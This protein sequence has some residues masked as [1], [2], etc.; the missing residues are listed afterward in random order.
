MQQQQIGLSSSNAKPVENQESDQ[1]SSS[2]NEQEANNKLQTQMTQQQNI[3]ANVKPLSNQQQYENEEVVNQSSA[4]L[5]EQVSTNPGQDAHQQTQQ[6]FTVDSVQQKNIHQ[7]Q[8]KNSSENYSFIH[9]PIVVNSNHRP[10]NQILEKNKENI[11]AELQPMPAFPAI[12]ND[13]TN[14]HQNETNESLLNLM[15]SL[16]NHQTS[17]ILPEINVHQFNHHVPQEQQI[18]SPQSNQLSSAS[19]LQAATASQQH[20]NQANISFSQY[21][22][23]HQG[24]LANNA[25]HEITEGKDGSQLV[26]SQ[27]TYL[28]NHNRPLSGQPQQINQ[29]FEHNVGQI[30]S[31]QEDPLKVDQIISQNIPLS[32]KPQQVQDQGHINVQS[33]FF[34]QQPTE[35]QHQQSLQVPQ[36]INA[37]NEQVVQPNQ[38]LQQ[39]TFE[40]N[41][42][43]QLIGQLQQINAIIN[44]QST[45]SQENSHILA[46]NTIPP[47]PIS[48]GHISSNNVYSSQQQQ[49]YNP[50][51]VFVQTL[52]INK[53]RPENLDLSSSLEPSIQQQSTYFQNRPVLQQNVQG[54]HV[55]HSVQLNQ[56]PQHLVN[57]QDKPFSEHSQVNNIQN[58]Y[59]TQQQGSISSQ[60]VPSAQQLSNSEDN[61]HKKPNATILNPLNEP[62]AFSP[63]QQPHI[64]NQGLIHHQQQ[65][66][67]LITLG[68]NENSGS[69]TH[70][71]T[72]SLENKPLHQGQI[73]HQQMN[74]TNEEKPIIDPLQ[75][76]QQHQQSVQHQ[77]T[78]QQN[79]QEQQS[80]Q[81]Q[82]LHQQSVQHQQ[83]IQQQ[84]NSNVKPLP[85]TYQS[86]QQQFLQQHQ[87]IL[88]QHQGSNENILPESYQG[89]QYQHQQQHFI[90][91]Q[92]ALN[93]DKPL[94]D[95]HQ[96]QHFILHQN[97]LPGS[98]QV[99]QQQQYIPQP[100]HQHQFSAYEV[101]LP[102]SYP[103]QQPQYPQLPQPIDNQQ[104]SFQQPQYIHQQQN[105]QQISQP[106]L[107]FQQ[108]QNIQQQASISLE[109][110]IQQQQ[111][112][113]QNLHQPQFISNEQPLIS[114]SNIQIQQQSFSAQ[115]TPQYQLHQTQHQ[116]QILPQQQFISNEK[117][118]I[119]TEQKLLSTTK[120]ASTL[121]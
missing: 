95:S 112:Q 70:L 104:Q 6:Q 10:I 73:I 31:S 24:Q 64:A 86:Y 25:Q 30:S 84:F 67:Q 18:H 109:H 16:E 72:I 23:T 21:L 120:Y 65:T 105:I 12:V 81:Q 49:G 2:L 80:L 63:F 57:S 35:N 113:S 33:V 97:P 7:Q 106:P 99:P 46:S 77:Q 45:T 121:N 27:Q 40:L 69:V 74:L 20:Q 14:S 61:L 82:Q 116:P 5:S 55:V 11:S 48:T 34:N 28:S 50:Q 66:N 110:Q 118:L 94:P 76:Q 19:H 53:D 90:P 37:H 119:L 56:I 8:H 111:S 32:L 79:L 71:Q 92:H 59:F 91:P 78:I 42:R 102:G 29:N 43:P 108:Q 13:S 9:E 115:N 103:I 107:N 75:Q 41:T 88:Q 87:Q 26:S 3:H 44:Q 85:G 98:Y 54:Q 17:T 58:S 38:Q 4:L 93:S 114:P 68:S 89:Q 36:S 39:N 100:F 62:T 83:T 101:P 52:L 60:I 47:E 51:N 1:T 96:T 117:P 15:E 22:T